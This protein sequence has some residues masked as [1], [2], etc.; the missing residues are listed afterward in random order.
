MQGLDKFTT[1]LVTRVEARPGGA[2]ALRTRFRVEA[3]VYGVQRTRPPY[4]KQ[5]KSL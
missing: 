3:S 2:A 1:A 5:R 4:A